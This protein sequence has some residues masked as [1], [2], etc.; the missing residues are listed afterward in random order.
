MNKTGQKRAKYFDKLIESLKLTG[1]DVLWALGAYLDMNPSA[2]KLFA[3]QLKVA[4][5]QN[6]AE[7]KTILD[8]Y[9]DEEGEEEEE[10]EEEENEEEEEDEL[11]DEN[12]DTEALEEEDEDE[13]E[14]LESL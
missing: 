8:F 1:A 5:E 4:Y 9:N 3:Q 11:E 7:E 13:D 2:K 14:E 6:W 12:V 10:S